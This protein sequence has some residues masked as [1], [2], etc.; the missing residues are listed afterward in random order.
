MLLL[1]FLNLNPFLHLNSMID[2]PIRQLADLVGSCL[3]LISCKIIFL[4]LNNLRAKT[5]FKEQLGTDE[6]S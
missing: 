4:S 2:F 5:F 6:D 3:H 1:L